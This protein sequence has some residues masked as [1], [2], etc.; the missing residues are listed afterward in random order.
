ME[1]KKCLPTTVALVLLITSACDRTASEY[2][3]RQIKAPDGSFSVT[4]PGEAIQQDMPEKS[5]AGGSFISHILNVR[6]S[7]TARFGCA[8]WQD[9]T[10]K[11]RTTD[12]ILN[13]ARD[14]GLSGVGG[15]LLSEQ[16][17]VFQGYPA[18]DLQAIARGNAAYDNRLVLVD[19]T[20]YTLLVVDASGRHDS[21][22]I[23]KFFASLALHNR[24]SESKAQ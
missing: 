21:A 22:N 8:W 23:H 2:Q 5:V 15:R 6:A 24:G 12:E 20:L 17:L 10:F 11:N 9:P 19:G 14:S 7:K 18:R 1:T 4:L 3:W 13:T 16:K